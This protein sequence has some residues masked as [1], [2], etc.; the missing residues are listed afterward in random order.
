MVDMQISIKEKIIRRC[1]LT[2]RYAVEAKDD[3]LRTLLMNI[4]DSLEYD[5]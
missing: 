5:I 1:S 4:C 2:V 3:D